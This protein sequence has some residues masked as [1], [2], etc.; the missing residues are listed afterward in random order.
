MGSND[1][2][3]RETIMAAVATLE[4]AHA[5]VADL[6]FDALTNPEVLA[7]LSRLETLAW[8]QP[9]VGHRFPG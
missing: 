9:A 8:R 5:S 1:G 2:D 4:S 6:S 7:V 3:D